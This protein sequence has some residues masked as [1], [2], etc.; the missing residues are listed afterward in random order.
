MKNKK[1]LTVVNSDNGTYGIIN[2][3]NY[4]Q[5]ELTDIVYKD[6]SGYLEIDRIKR[7][8]IT[9]E[10]RYRKDVYEED[11]RSRIN[12][13]EEI[14]GFLSS[15]L[16]EFTE[17][18]YKSNIT[19]FL[20]YCNENGLNPLKISVK[21]T[22]DYLRYLRDMNYSSRSIRTMYN[23]ISS[24]YG[25]LH[26]NYFEVIKINPFLDNKL[27]KIMDKFEKDFIT[28]NDYKVL[29]EEIT[30]KNKP[31]YLCCIKFLWK[32]GYRVGV[33]RKMKIYD[34]LK[35]KSESKGKEEKGILSK[36]EYKDFIKYN[37]QSINSAVFSSFIKKT[38]NKLKKDNKIS[39]SFSV[40][41]I[42]RA[43]IKREILKCKTIDQLIKTSRRFHK[44]LGTSIG[45]FEGK[46]DK[47]Y[48]N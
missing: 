35:Y 1:E 42:R 41:D 15:Q 13:E 8:K 24:F 30:Q 28:E 46:Y 14:E 9:A 31:E 33:F 7:A 34:S 21:N 6:I 2:P 27:P 16:S 20:K 45:Y 12:L 29:C 11:L 3:D 48:T 39:C 22:R 5:N 17:K 37:V 40:H 23:S 32:T 19:K 38:T 4:S 47:E 10:E 44:D 25:K 26:K 36:T 43:V 18:S